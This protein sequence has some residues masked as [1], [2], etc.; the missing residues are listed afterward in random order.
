MSSSKQHEFLTNNVG[1]YLNVLRPGGNE[2]EL[3]NFYY[4]RNPNFL[5]GNA[6]SATPLYRI[7]V[8]TGLA[9]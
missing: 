8:D 7:S 3:G 9:T 6:K 2:T 4:A 1:R 5:P